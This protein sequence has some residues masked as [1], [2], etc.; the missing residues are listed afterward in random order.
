MISASVVGSPLRGVQERAAAARRL[1]GDV[2]DGDDAEGRR[3]RARPGRA[4]S[5]SSCRSTAH[6]A[7]AARATRARAATRTRTSWRCTSSSRSEPAAATHER[8]DP[9]E[10]DTH[11]V[12]RRDDGGRLGAADRLR[13]AARRP[14]RAGARRRS[15]P[16]T[17]AACCC[18]TRTTSA[19][20]RA[21]RSATW[22]RDKNIRFALV[23]RDDDPI[24]WDFGSAARHHQLYCPWLPESSWRAWVP[25]MRGA[26]PDATGVPDALAEMICGGAARARARR[27]AGRHGRA[28]HDHARWRCSARAS[29]SPTR[30]R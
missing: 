29:R 7:A 3:P 12:A 15:R 23:L 28:G 17:S 4:R 27:R 26:M 19:T 13:P 5:A 10:R 1:L 30:S 25:P 6:A 11:R 18:S 8:G 20:S 9:G 16:P 24:L 22:E 14:A 2:H 21:R